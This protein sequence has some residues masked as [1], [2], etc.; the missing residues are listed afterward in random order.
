[1]KTPSIWICVD[2]R[3]NCF[4][5]DKDYYMIK[6]ELW[7]KIGV[8]EKMLCMDCLESRIG[9]KLIEQ[10]ILVCPLTKENYYTSK[11]LKNTKKEFNIRNNIGKAKYVV[12]FY[13]GIKKHKDGSNFFDIEIFKNKKKLKTFT[14]MLKSDNYIEK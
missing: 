11:I 2:C 7:E 12:N 6:N 10:D 13:D 9:R 14:N 4:H 8:G 5:D 3:K 1:M